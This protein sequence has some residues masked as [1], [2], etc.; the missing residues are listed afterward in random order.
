[1]SSYAGQQVY[2]YMHILCFVY[3]Y[4]TSVN[5]RYSYADI[6]DQL[7]ELEQNKKVSY[8]PVLQAVYKYA[9]LT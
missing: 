3:V 7:R 9:S 2:T 6:E 8:T 4:C 1:M 5:A